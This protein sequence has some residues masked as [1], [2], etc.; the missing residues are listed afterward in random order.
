MVLGSIPSAPFADLSYELIVNEKP[1]V[2]A[3]RFV[4]E[5]APKYHI[6]AFDQRKQHFS[7]L[8]HT[9]R[10]SY[11]FTSPNGGYAPSA[12]EKIGCA[13]ESSRELAPQEGGLP[14]TVSQLSQQVRARLLSGTPHSHACSHTWLSLS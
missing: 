3:M 5:E 8:V 6:V 9:S 2:A 12:N 10:H 13:V 14:V 1:A 11:R 7:H 4:A